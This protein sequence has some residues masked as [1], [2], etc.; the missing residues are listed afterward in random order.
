MFAMRSQ[1]INE[2]EFSCSSILVCQKT[3]RHNGCLS[4][5]ATR[6]VNYVFYALNRSLFD[7]NAMVLSFVS[8]RHEEG[9]SFEVQIGNRKP[10]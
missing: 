10:K 1:Y 6:H 4:I 5:N 9:S 3:D 7:A 2:N 8:Q